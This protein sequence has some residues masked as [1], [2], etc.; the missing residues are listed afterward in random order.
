[1]SGVWSFVSHDDPALGAVFVASLARALSDL[2]RRVLLI[3][4]CPAYPA[5]DIGR[6][7]S[8][9]VV[10]PISDAEKMSPEAIFLSPAHKGKGEILLAPLFPGEEPS[11]AHVKA[12]AC[13]AKADLVLIHAQPSYASVARAASDA[14]LL[15][16]RTDATSLRAAAYLAAHE[17]FDAF[18][19]TGLVLTKESFKAGASLTE[20]ADALSLSLFGILPRFPD[21]A[22]DLA[23]AN[24]AKRILGEQVILLDNILTAKKQR[25]LY[26]ERASY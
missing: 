21:K 14:V 20:T 2:G 7:V 1:M 18:L 12:C 5:L 3:D 22:F 16:T 17:T 15:M 9:R 23:V 19:L 24:I 6:D 13:A 8:D 10:Y 25:K 4:L 11:G 26:F